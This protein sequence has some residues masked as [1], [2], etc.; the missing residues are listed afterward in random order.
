MGQWFLFWGWKKPPGNVILLSYTSVAFC[1]FSRFRWRRRLLVISA[2]NDED[3]AYSQQLSALS[4]QACNFGEWEA[5]SFLLSQT[6]LLLVNSKMEHRSLDHP[7][8]LQF[9]LQI[10]KHTLYFI[11]YKVA[12]RMEL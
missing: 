10:P 9:R 12:F 2:P 5:T 7:N 8:I 6:T 11:D 3:W 4:G 1:F